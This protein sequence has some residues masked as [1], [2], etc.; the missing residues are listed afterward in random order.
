LMNYIYGFRHRP[1]SCV[2][3]LEAESASNVGGFRIT[4]TKDKRRESSPVHFLLTARM[5]QLEVINFH[6]FG[7]DTPGILPG[8]PTPFYEA[9]QRQWLLHPAVALALGRRSDLSLGPVIQYSVTDSTP[10]RLLS[11]VR[12]YGFGRYGQAGMRLNLHLDTRDVLRDPRHGVLLDLTGT[13]FPA[14]WDVTSQFGSIAGGVIT[15]LTFPVPI[16]PVLVL[17]GGA[18]KVYG[19]FPFHEAAFVGGRSMLRSLD[20]QR[21]AGDASLYGSAELRLPLFKFAFIVPL[22]VGI[23]GV[24]DASRVYVNGE[25]PGGWHN[26]K[27]VGFWIGVPDPSTAVR[28]CKRF[29]PAGPC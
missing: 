10:D 16:H 27:G 22:D 8:D 26:A 5:S 3:G 6:G 4:L 19:P 9:R 15:Y 18:K 24:V 2:V 20:A 28:V 29:G 13:V 11:A 12:P 23:F 1:F 25:S 7:N 14:L 21:Y 17:R